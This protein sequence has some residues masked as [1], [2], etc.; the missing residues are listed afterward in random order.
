[1]G[2]KMRFIKTINWTF[3]NFD[4]VYKI[5][6]ENSTININQYYSYMY[7]KNGEKLDFWDYP[8]VIEVSGKDVAVD[9]DDHMKL[10]EILLNKVCRYFSGNHFGVF[11]VEKHEYEIWIE[12][13]E[14]FNAKQRESENQD[15]SCNG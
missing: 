9:A 5:C 14:W 8:D 13:M 6:H 3:I 1:M 4:E 10:N 12:F 11:D 2:V 7:L 15:T